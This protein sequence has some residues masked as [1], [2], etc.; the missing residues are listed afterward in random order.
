MKKLFITLALALCLL[1]TTATAVFRAEPQTTK[2]VTYNEGISAS[3]AN[4]E[5]YG[6]AVLEDAVSAVQDEENE[7]EEPDTPDEPVP[8][9]EEDDIS[10]EEKIRANLNPDSDVFYADVVCPGHIWEDGGLWDTEKPELGSYRYCSICGKPESVDE[11]E[12]MEDED[13]CETSGNAR[14]E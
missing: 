3:E 8:D 10:N 13:I 5:T 11:S 9:V 12:S 14:E 7:P 6:N 2:R 4:Y 1:A